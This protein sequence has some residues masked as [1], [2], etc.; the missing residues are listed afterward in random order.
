VKERLDSFRVISQQTKS[1]V[2]RRAKQS[3]DHSSLMIMIDV[4]TMLG[5][6]VTT[7]GSAY[8]V[9]G[10]EHLVIQFNR[11]PIPESQFDGTR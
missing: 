1:L 4:E 11:D 8:S 7:A 2:A 10:F 5:V 3:P 9:L 6:S